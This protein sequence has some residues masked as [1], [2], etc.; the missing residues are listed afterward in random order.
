[1]SIIISPNN[2]IWIFHKSYQIILIINI[3]LID[4]NSS[5]KM[6]KPSSNCK[7]LSNIKYFFSEKTSIFI[8]GY[9]FILELQSHFHKQMMVI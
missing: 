3:I 9:K 1:M 2:N 7:T 5:I 6:V 4:K 8:V